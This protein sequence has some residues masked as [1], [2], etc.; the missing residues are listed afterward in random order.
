MEKHVT[1][2]L[3]LGVIQPTKSP[4]NCPTFAVAKNNGGIQLVQDF[5]DLNAHTHMDKCSTEDIGECIGDIGDIGQ[6]GSAIF[7]TID[8][9]AGF[10]QLLLYP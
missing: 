5:W 2:W 8:L 4:F 7:T 6:S 3:K 10:W 9:T 1:K